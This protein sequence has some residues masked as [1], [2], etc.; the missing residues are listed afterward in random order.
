MITQEQFNA[1]MNTYLESLATKQPSSWSQE[2]RDW[3]ESCGIIKGDDGGQMQ[4]MSFTT[5]EQMVTF[6][7]RLYHMLS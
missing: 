3:A 1:M 2:E 4:Y 5:R 6:L 7:Y